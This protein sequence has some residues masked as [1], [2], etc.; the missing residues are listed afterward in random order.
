MT[1]WGSI[2]NTFA[3]KEIKKYKLNKKDK[4]IID[5]WE[6]LLKEAKKTKKYNK[7]YTYG[8]YQIEKELNTFKND[9]NNKKVYDYKILNS[10]IETLKETLKEYYLKEITPKLFQYELLK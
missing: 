4:E 5:L 2:N 1:Y 9:K 8:L 10:L 7:N 3:N 6:R